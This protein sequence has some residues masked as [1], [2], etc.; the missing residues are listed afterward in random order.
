MTEPVAPSDASLI[1]AARQHCRIAHHVP[2]RIRLRFDPLG[3]A[4]VLRA[5]GNRAAALETTLR[6]VRGIRA[7]EMNLAAC[8]L[9]VQYDPALLPPQ[10]WERLLTGPAAAASALLAELLPAADPAA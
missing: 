2:G 8:S 9:T 7:T 1:L 5:L 10:S 4:G 6:R 3:L